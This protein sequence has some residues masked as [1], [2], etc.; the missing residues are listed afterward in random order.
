MKKIVLLPLDE[1]PCNALFPGKLFSGD[2]VRIAVPDYLGDKKQPSDYEKLEAFLWEQCRD[3]EGLVLSMDQLLYGGLLSSRLHTLDGE[4]VE[5][6]LSLVKRLREA[7]PKLTIYAFHCIMRCP[8]YSSSD[9]EPDYYEAYGAQIHRSGSAVHRR[10]LGLFTAEEERR[11]LAEVPEEILADYLGRRKFNLSFNKRT[12]ELLQGGLIDF[13]VIPQDDSA[14]FGYTA[15][16][17][18]EVRDA[19]AAMHLQTKV[20]MY[21]GAD[22]AG[23]TLI[24][25][26]LLKDRASRPKVYVRYAAQSAPQVIPAYEDRSLG[27]TIKAHLLAAG[28]RQAATPGEADFIL[29]ITCPGG[30]MEEASVQPVRNGAYCVERNL[31]EFVQE[32]CALADEG[33]RIV[34]CDNAYANGADLEVIDLL[35]QTNLLQ[36]LSGYA[37]WNTS[38]NSLGTAIAQG[39]HACVCGG[40][41]KDFLML[42]YVEDALYCA[43]VRKAVTEQCLPELG[44]DYFSVRER[45]GQAARLVKEKL[46]QAVPKY[47]PTLQKHIAIPNVILPWRRMFEADITVRWIP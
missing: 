18:Q 2:A 14:P 1:R 44:M 47:L 17:Q 16:D 45:D 34:L 46:I 7:Y 42:R 25:R 27:E 35:N 36:R 31:T 33:K 40:V 5:R 28:C 10:M 22:E 24:S 38:A 15:L 30:K 19:I 39:V 3:A 37:G 8:A 21:P 29:G 20:L 32:L 41:P 11:A 43:V 6:R 26:M 9:E 4:T 12:L 13:L 23:L